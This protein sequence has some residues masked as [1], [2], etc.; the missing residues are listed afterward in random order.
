MLNRLQAGRGTLR[1][2]AL[3]LAAICLLAAGAA[4]GEADEAR[5]LR[6]GFEGMVVPCSWTQSDDSNG[7]IPIEGSN[8]YLAGFEVMYMQRVC[9]LLGYRLE[10]YKYDWDGLMMAVPSGK[11]DCA[12]DMIA[13]TADRRQTMDFTDPYYFADTVAVVRAD[14]PYARADSVS[15]L[16]GA[17]ATSMLNTTWYTQIARIPNVDARPAMENVPAMIVALQSDKVDLILVDRPTAE[18]IVTANPG[19]S[20]APMPGSGNFN[21]TEDET[22]VAIALPKGSDALRAELN[23]AVAQISHA[24][25]EAMIA[26]A[27]EIQPMEQAESDV[28]TLGF[29]AM[30]KLLINEYGPI[31]MQGAGV[32]VLLALLGTLL[33]T[34]IG[35]LSGAISAYE[36]SPDASPLCRGLLRAGHAIVNFYVWLFRGTPMMVQAMVIYYGAAQL[37]GWD[38]NPIAAGVVIVSLNTGAYMSETVRGGIRSVDRGQSEGAEAIGMSEFQTMLLVVL[39]QGFR[40]IVPQIGNYLIANI[41]DTSMLSVITVGELFYRGREAAGQYFRFF[42]VFLIVSAIYLCLTTV[43]TLALRAVERRMAGKKNYE[44]V[45]R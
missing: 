26:R 36:I 7:A 15:A 22:A 6:V 10:A 32:A 45:D 19:L 44:I 33:G 4:F 1:M 24:E 25:M 17:R 23:R 38:M 27:C 35:A 11:V 16:S 42:E 13:P 40:S 8:Q 28:E 39:P 3:A 9:E 5:V 41:K 20:I 34:L 18:G 21:L 37:L 12:I 30:V 14:G 2:L 43:A 29:F 31:F